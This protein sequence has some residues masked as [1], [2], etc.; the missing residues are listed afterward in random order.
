M[1]SVGAV[2]PT[3]V[4][5]PAKPSAGSTDRPKANFG[6]NSL[7][8]LRAGVNYAARGPRSVDPTRLPSYASG[9]RKVVFGS[10]TSGSTVA[11]PYFR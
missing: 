5:P 6:S 3:V 10:T 2:A 4:S 8:G 1:S 7:D 9:S 11:H